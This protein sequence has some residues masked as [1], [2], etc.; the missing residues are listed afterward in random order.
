MAPQL[1][2]GLGVRGA[3]NH[4]VGIRRA[5]TIVGVNTDAAAPIFE[6]A[7]LGV[8]ADWRAIAKALLAALE[9]PA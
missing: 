4:L 8:V 2:L 5:G 1:Y 3:W 6:Q 7:D 9:S